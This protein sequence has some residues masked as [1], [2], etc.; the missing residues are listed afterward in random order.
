ML[1]S[2]EFF[3]VFEF[4]DKCEELNPVFLVF[5]SGGV[6]KLKERNKL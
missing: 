1:D 5:T 2:P 6:P 3:P 4:D